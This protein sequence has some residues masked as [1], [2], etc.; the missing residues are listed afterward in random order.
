GIS[1]TDKTHLRDLFDKSNINNV[2]ER[3]GS[4]EPNLFNF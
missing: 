3:F 2:N 1:L 4:S